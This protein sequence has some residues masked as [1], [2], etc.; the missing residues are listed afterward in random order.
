MASSLSFNILV[1]YWEKEYVTVHDLKKG[2]SSKCI[3]TKK[4]FSIYVFDL[5]FDYRKQ[6]IMSIV[7]NAD[8]IKTVFRIETIEEHQYV[9]WYACKRENE[10]LLD[11]M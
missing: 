1:E 8:E 11:N 4:E 3:K 5:H 7:L 6:E 10:A 2:L 9:T